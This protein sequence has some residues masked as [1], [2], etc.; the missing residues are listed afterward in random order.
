M[1]WDGDKS[2]VDREVEKEKKG[3][4]HWS[5]EYDEELDVGK[6]LPQFKLYTLNNQ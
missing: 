6:V 3:N 5:D 4:G 1:S 2:N